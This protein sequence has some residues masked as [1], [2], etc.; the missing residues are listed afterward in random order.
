MGRCNL[1]VGMPKQWLHGSL[2]GFG[3]QEWPIIELQI[4]DWKLEK[5]SILLLLITV[6][7]NVAFVMYNSLKGSKYSM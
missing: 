1:R 2:R 4:A 7:R 6:S 5:A 3:R